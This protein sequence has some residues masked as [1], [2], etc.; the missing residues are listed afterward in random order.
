M[1]NIVIIPSI[2]IQPNKV[3]SYNSIF[4]KSS[5]DNK[6][7]TFRELNK[8]KA[9]KFDNK[10]KSN[11]V[12]KAFHN[13]QIS[14]NAYRTLK[15]KINWL[16]FLANKSKQTTTKGKTIFNFKMAFITL[17]LPSKQKHNT[18]IITKECLNQFLTEVR[19]Q[20]NMSN[21][22]WRLEFQKNGNVHYH[23]ATDV[24]ID[25]SIIQKIWNRQLYKLGYIQ[26]FQKRMSKFNLY[27]YNKTFNADNKIDF[28]K[29]KER[30]NS[31]RASNWAN[32]PSVDVKS[33]ISDKSIANYI[34]KYFSKGEMDNKKCNELDNEDNSKSLRL[35]FCSRSLS[36][37]T[38]VSDFCDAFKEDIYFI[39]STAKDKLELFHKYCKV[40]YFEI[41][42]LPKDS[43]H[44]INNLLRNYAKK[45]E[46]IPWSVPVPAD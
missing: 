26:D 14:S 34:S 15:S 16:Y 37:L 17:T 18:S 24:F 29:I 8:T 45:N 43:F 35:W 32:P 2:S 31:G 20:Y 41:R 3:V 21:Y 38:K 25:Y 33:V 46:Y 22:V 9:I 39:I 6:L 13:F 5:V 27:S 44:F 19:Q 30:Y 11:T 12:N 1:Q 28:N 42:S 10:L 40:L 23:I 4:V 36:K 7:K